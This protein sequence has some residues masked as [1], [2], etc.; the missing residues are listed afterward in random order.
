MSLLLKGCDDSS[1]VRF[2]APRFAS[3]F[4]LY[5]GGRLAG[6]RLTTALVGVLVGDGDDTG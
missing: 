2:L 6:Y 3:N 1:G 5:L 4:C